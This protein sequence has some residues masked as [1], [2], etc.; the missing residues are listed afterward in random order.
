MIEGATAGAKFR[1]E[2]GISNRIG[3]DLECE[4]RLFSDPLCSRVHAVVFTN[5]DGWWVRDE[6][7]RNGTF[8]NGQKIDEARIVDGTHLR[9]GG[10]SFIFSETL[11]ER[12]VSA[13][14]LIAQTVILDRPILNQ[15]SGTIALPTLSETHPEDLLALC[16]LCVQMLVS[17]GPDDV[18]RKALEG[19][20]KATRASWAGFLWITDDGELKPKL[21]LPETDD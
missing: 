10:T 5:E 11:V 3:R 20:H 21:V 7:S 16:D 19:L 17:E 4:V 12:E 1:L 14:P 15:K 2:A 18:I 6:K 8:L 13:A 9:L